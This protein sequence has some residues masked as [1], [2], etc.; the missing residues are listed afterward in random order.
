MKQSF[1][2]RLPFYY[3]WINV[4]VASV[5]MA[6]TLPGRTHGLGLITKPLLADLEI[7]EIL[8]GHI[9]LATALLGALVCLPVGYLIDRFGVRAVAI[10]VS[11][12]LGGAVAATAAAVGPLSLSVTLFA[13]RG[14]GQGALSVVSMAIVAKWF[15]RRLGLA[16]GV[17]SVLLSIGS[18]AAVL[19]T[20]Y[21]VK[22]AGWR[23]AW[24]TCAFALLAGMAPLAWLFVRDTPEACG[25]PGDVGPTSAIPESS[26]ADFT[27]AG[28]LCSP[29]FWVFAL[30][31]SVFNLVW[32]AVTLW[33]ELILNERGFNGT[34]DATRVLAILSASGLI[35][36]LVGG[37]LA[38]R[39][40][41][42]RL[43]SGGLLVL[44][45]S[46]ALFPR[47]TS[48]LQLQLYAVAMGLTGGIVTVVFF[49]A[50]R[51]LFGAAQLG[52]IQGAAQLITVL[53]SSVGP[54]IMAQSHARTGSYTP[55]F[56]ALAA[57]VTVLALAAA[58]VPITVL[59]REPA[60]AASHPWTAAESLPDE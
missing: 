35:S 49:A 47:I 16:M 42:G 55:M 37:A 50:W 13:V 1:P 51:H 25:L 10:G 41:L 28:A 9:N 23:T 7:S 33:N 24:N 5:A 48:M 8:Y 45:I 27:L 44:A 2:Q 40:N 36:N 18:V 46:L 17:Y 32:S 53:A 15:S 12:G 19:G 26:A 31:T 11:V 52:R 21:L 20:G 57:V 60:A 22:T 39:G 59:R 30:G 29:A 54:E 4:V 6:A 38:R 3:G 14:L 56:Y 43:L 58:V 34:D